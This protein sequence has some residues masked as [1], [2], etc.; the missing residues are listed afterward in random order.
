MNSCFFL[1]ESLT[2]SA[3]L[4]CNDVILAHCNLCLPGSSDS[5]A[6]VFQVA[7]IIGAH[8]HNQLIF[9]EL[10]F[11]HVSQAGLEAPT[12]GDLPALAS[13]SGG[14]TGMS[15]HAF[16]VSVLIMD[17]SLSCFCKNIQCFTKSWFYL[18]Y[19]YF[20]YAGIKNFFEQKQI[21]QSKS[22]NATNSNVKDVGA[23]EPNRKNATS[24]IL[25]EEV[26]L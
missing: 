20:I 15:Y 3:G 26:G 2:L 16:P 24:L 1:R 5:P 14:I 17:F 6:S 22:T 7:G 23:E 18:K 9:V 21:T 19:Q 25:F 12:S 11:C 8:H 10:R 13:Q 4:E